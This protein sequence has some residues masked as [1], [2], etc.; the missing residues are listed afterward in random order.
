ML[1]ILIDGELALISGALS[2]SAADMDSEAG[3]IG[4]DEAHGSSVAGE[5][6]RLFKVIDN[7]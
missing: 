3:E 2:D 7:T 6:V 5:T 4:L 1:G